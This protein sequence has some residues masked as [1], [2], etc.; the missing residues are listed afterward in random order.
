MRTG[1]RTL[2]NAGSGLI[3]VK[4]EA[5]GRLGRYRRETLIERYGADTATPDVLLRVSEG[6][7]RSGE[8]HYQRCRAVFGWRTI[9]AHRA[10]SKD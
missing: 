1:A 10:P 7:D 9:E 2:G 8:G 5:C 4:C 6:Y 3:V